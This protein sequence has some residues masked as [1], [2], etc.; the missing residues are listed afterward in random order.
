VFLEEFCG[1]FAK[2]AEQVVQLAIVRVIDTNSYTVV[3][4]G[5]EPDFS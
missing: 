3:E 2:A 1:V 4:D 5:V